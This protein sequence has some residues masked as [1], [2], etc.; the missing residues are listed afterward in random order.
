MCPNKLKEIEYQKLD[1]RQIQVMAGQDFLCV[2]IKIF[3]I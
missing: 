1:Q 3:Y 2:Y